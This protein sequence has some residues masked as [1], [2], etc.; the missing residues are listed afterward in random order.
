MLIKIVNSKILFSDDVHLVEPDG[1]ARWIPPETPIQ[2]DPL[3]DIV[4]DLDMVDVIRKG[5]GND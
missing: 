5:N 1:H 4:I 3:M 2:I